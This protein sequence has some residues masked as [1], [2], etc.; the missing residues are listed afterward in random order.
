MNSLIYNK[1]DN[2]KNNL[3]FS[4]K[5]IKIMLSNFSEKNN[6]FWASYGNLHFF[7]ETLNKKFTEKYKEI[8]QNNSQNYSF[9]DFLYKI[10][11][12]FYKLTPYYNYIP[13]YNFFDQNQN[14]QNNQNNNQQS[15]S[16]FKNITQN[17]QIHNDIVYSTLNDTI[18]RCENIIKT[19]HLNERIYRNSHN[20]SDQN[21]S[22]K[23]SK[24]ND[25]DTSAKSQN[26]NN[27]NQNNNSSY[28]ENSYDNLYK[29]IQND[30]LDTCFKSFPQNLLQFPEMMHFP[31]NPAQNFLPGYIFS[32]NMNPFNNFHT[33]NPFHSLNASLNAFNNINTLCNHY[34][35]FPFNQYLKNNGDLSLKDLS[36]LRFFYDNIYS[37]KTPNNYPLFNDDFWVEM[38]KTNGKSM[39]NG[40][41]NY[42]KDIENYQKSGEFKMVTTPENTFVIGKNIATTPGKIVYRNEIFELIQYNATTENV[43]QNPVL[44]C[45][46]WI[47]KYYVLD[48]ESENSLVKWLV[49]KGHTVF[50]ISWVNPSSDNCKQKFSDYIIKGTIVA[51][52]MALMICGNNSKVNCIGYCLG[53]T[54]MAITAAYLKSAGVNYISSLTFLASLVDFSDCGIIG[55]FIHENIIDAI[56][57]HVDNVGYLSGNSMFSTF[58]MVRPKDMLWYY[59]INNYMLGKDPKPLS[60]LHW[61]A[62][63]TNMAGECHKY[64]LRNLYL[65]NDLIKGNLSIEGTKINLQNID[66]PIYMVATKDDHIAPWKS[67]YKGLQMAYKSSKEKR[68]VLGESGHVMGIVNP[69][70]AKRKYG[71]YVVDNRSDPSEVENNIILE[72]IL[73]SDEWIQCAKKIDGSWWDDMHRWLINHQTHKH[74]DKGEIMYD[75]KMVDEECES[76]MRKSR[77]IF[78]VDDKYGE[79]A[80]GLYVLD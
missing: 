35:S 75:E 60:I 42:M 51:I 41:D 2:I 68:F 11:E 57:E 73:T 61:N 20:N 33:F 7:I 21:S 30:F 19:R 46:A 32:G 1:Q 80:P 27:Q 23:N 31:Q 45:P 65:K 26:T 49:E 70:T 16:F 22:E 63:S 48:L 39:E 10:N 52:E 28:D 6:L 12:N 66:L 17:W 24:K 56:D 79:P 44:I 40:F 76:C 54:V 8:I 13:Y 62:D 47:N 78:T 55:A 25:S 36:L 43:Y 3:Y 5:I 71:Y 9:M 53:G 59:V 58:S 14:N 77:P 29:Q 37:A 34:P 74:K 50:M 72:N 4:A 18:D 67:T 64:Y 15:S 38:I 69:P